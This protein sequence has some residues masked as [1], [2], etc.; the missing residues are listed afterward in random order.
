MQ[1]HLQM[2]PEKSKTTSLSGDNG[3]ALAQNQYKSIPGLR[4][5]IFFRW[6]CVW[7]CLLVA[8]T[9]G[10][11]YLASSSDIPR[12]VPRELNWL[13]EASSI[14]IESFLFGLVKCILASFNLTFERS[15]SRRLNSAAS[16]RFKLGYWLWFRFGIGFAFRSLSG[17]RSTA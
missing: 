11:C 5:C 17:S 8:P 9:P 15:R 6:Q 14:E 3:R 7:V 4:T 16:Q 1:A 2:D 13:D 12:T 10:L